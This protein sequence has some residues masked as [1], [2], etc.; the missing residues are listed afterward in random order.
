MSTEELWIYHPKLT[1]E[2]SKAQPIFKGLKT[3]LALQSR[4]WKRA[5]APKPEA[6]PEGHT[7]NQEA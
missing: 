3:Y 5:T 4:G 6:Q 1:G 7:D 2:G